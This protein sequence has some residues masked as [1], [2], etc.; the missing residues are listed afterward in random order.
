MTTMTFGRVGLPTSYGGGAT[1][2]PMHPPS[3]WA[4]AGGRVNV[5]G[6]QFVSGW[7]ANSRAALLAWREA[8]LGH[9]PQFATTDESTIPVTVYDAP[10]FN[11]WYQ[12]ESVSIPLNPGTIGSSSSTG[13]LALPWS[14]ELVEVANHQM[15][16]L[17]GK[18][19]AAPYANGG[20][21]PNFMVAVPSVTGNRWSL[22]ATESVAADVGTVARYTIS[23][24]S[25]TF[26]HRF[27]LKPQDAYIGAARIYDNIGGYDTP[28][29]GQK[30]WDYSQLGA[31]GLAGISI[32]NGLV[33][34]KFPSPSGSPSL[35]R[36]F[37][38][39]WWDGT[40]WD[41]TTGG[42]LLFDQS[43]F[44]P[45]PATDNFFVLGATVI[46][47]TA[48]CCVVRFT[49]YITNAFSSTTRRGF[50]DVTI[51]RGSRLVTFKTDYLKAG[52]VDDAYIY[53]PM[54]ARTLVNGAGVETA[55]NAQGNKLIIGG[56]T[57]N[58]N[59]PQISGFESF[60]LGCEVGGA[61]G[62]LSAANQVLEGYAGLTETVK[63][64]I[65]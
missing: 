48:E 29:V 25:A 21:T 41:T 8:M 62:F 40:Q 28:V 27:N 2:Y 1:P 65:S 50:F 35:I 38:V 17:E 47:N 3:S 30:T 34:F 23:G 31:A 15:P 60:F 7:T 44:A 53:L 36:S 16:L 39:E 55:T 43:G 49:T 19:N 63:A 64:V 33:R 51:R 58:S 54:G 12:V 18:V 20:F 61:G 45:D 14:V 10:Q 42:K 46:R 11:G 37:T 6:V 26:L 32:S 59:N 13:Y 52:V 4:A 24:S 5:Q 56:S 9:S 57:L 22:T